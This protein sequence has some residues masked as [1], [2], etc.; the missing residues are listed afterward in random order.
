MWV[1]TAGPPG[2]KIVLFDYEA[3]RESAVPDRLLAGYSGYLMTD[4]YR[5]YDR[6]GK[7][8]GMTHLACW[9]HARRG[10]VDAKS[11]QAKGKTGKA[12]EMLN[13]IGQLYRVEKE[14]KDADAKDRFKARQSESV[15]VLTAIRKW[16][17]DN[18]Q[19]VLPSHK[20][21]QAIA[22]THTLWAR[23]V[24]YVEHGDLPIDN[25]PAE[26]A[27]RPFV[28]GRKAW[29][30]SD[31]QAGARA[32]ALIY[33]LVETAKGCGVEPYCWLVYVLK[34]LPLA[35]TAD[36]YEKLL[37]WNIHPEHLAIDFNS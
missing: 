30:F 5:A 23:L 29:L 8:E 10:F 12:D 28:M 22:Y 26:N 32:S 14:Y 19:I 2:R 13:L 35:Q 27:I 4:G 1:Q 21:G 34:R 31:T 15:P 18:I 25:N 3:S 36:D 16:L 33:S 11:L 17:D 9:A 37:P 24:R 6:V 20:L 7:K